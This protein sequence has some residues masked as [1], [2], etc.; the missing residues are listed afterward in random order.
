MLKNIILFL[1]IINTANAS[2]FLV[3]QSTTSTADSG[4]YDFLL[5]RYEEK[6]GID[7]RVV[8]VGTGQA[9]KNAKNGDGDL[10]IVHSEDDENEFIK[11][12][13]GIERK[14]LMY[15]DFIII[16]PKKDPEKLKYKKTIKDVF[17]T[18][19][20]KKLSFLTRGDNSGTHKREVLLWKK[21]G[22]NHLAKFLY[23]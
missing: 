10:L 4:L 13:Y 17:E 12:G 8:A 14:K 1:F 7:I 9:I 19:K 20:I 21:S 6:T 23:Q 5:P 3:V 15:N 18:I 22:I 16:G 11:N 2:E